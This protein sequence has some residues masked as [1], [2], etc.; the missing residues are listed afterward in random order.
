MD[1]KKS[2]WSKCQT[3][4]GPFLSE[5]RS[6]ELHGEA[7]DQPWRRWQDLAKGKAASGAVRS[8]WARWMDWNL[9]ELHTR[10]RFSG[11]WML[12]S[13]NAREPLGRG[14]KAERSPGPRSL[15][16]GPVMPTK[17]PIFQYIWNQRWTKT[18]PAT[19]PQ[20]SSIPN[21]FKAISPCVV[22]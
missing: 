10:S 1:A 21:Q 18:N 16:G 19:Y 2:K 8:V 11:T 22:L 9:E 14:W 7:H 5:Q 13:A 20:P 6:S 15:E 12:P 4:Q 3:R 17:S